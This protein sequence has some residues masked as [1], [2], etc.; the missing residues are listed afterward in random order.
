MQSPACLICM[1]LCK[2]SA[3]KPSTLQQTVERATPTISEKPFV[4]SLQFDLPPQD[5]AVVVVDVI[6]KLFELYQRQFSTFFRLAPFG[7][8]DVSVRA[9]HFHVIFLYL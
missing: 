8:A 9:T 1:L 7:V 5:G 4:V 2:I 3:P 6:C